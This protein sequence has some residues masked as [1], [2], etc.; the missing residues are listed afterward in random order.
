MAAHAVRVSTEPVT[1]PSPAA[2]YTGLLRMRGVPALF[3]VSLANVLGMSLQIFA[4]SLVVYQQTDSALWSSAAFAA[5][6]LPQLF[7]GMLLTSLAD[8]WPARPVLV[9]GALVRL[10]GAVVLA[11]SSPPPWLAIAVVALV[12]LW[13]PLPAAAQSALLTRLVT[14]DAYVLGRSVL[15]LIM[16][17]AQLLGLA[18]GG[19]VVQWLGASAAFAT[20]AGL[21]LLAL[22]CVGALP[23]TPVES[24]APDR[25][26]AGDTWRGNREL[27]G[28]R[29]VRRILLAWWVGPMLLVG[30]EALVVAY[31]GERG[32][33]A[34]PAGL[35]L[36]AFPAGAAVGHL[37]VGRWLSP[38]LRRRST[39]WL[40]AL[41]GL[42]LL[43]LAWHPSLLVTGLCFAV[44][45]AATAYELGSQQA[46]VDSVP[47]ARRGLAFG[48]FS[49]GLMGGQGVGPVLAGVLAD[50]VGAGLTMS[51]LGV[52]IVLAAALVGR[53][54]DTRRPSEALPDPTAGPP[55]RVTG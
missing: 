30:A 11:V 52:A 42:S 44:A 1:P 43:P 46:F 36:A 21:Q 31:V 4:L 14:G 54:P 39:P 50:V 3:G 2:T 15:M 37:V 49:T 12:A 10:T 26:R 51:V 35:L 38:A 28:D 29:A 33:S 6:F 17:G 32:G 16:S 7:G 9:S 13:Q 45:S 34:A 24:S 20:V 53:V 22:L 47:V 18:A 19:V 23:R 41:V 5:G 25:W 40:F 8:R 55:R 48:L 27:L